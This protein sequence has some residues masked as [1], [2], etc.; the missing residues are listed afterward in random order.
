MCAQVLRALP[1][2]IGDEV[3]AQHLRAS[4]R[5]A[6]L[7]LRDALGGPEPADHFDPVGPMFHAF[8]RSAVLRPSVLARAL[9]LRVTGLDEA[10][11]SYRSQ[12]TRPAG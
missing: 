9:N 12:N 10:M 4:W 11:R 7:F 1:A 2:R 6:G 3:R 8:A 5:V